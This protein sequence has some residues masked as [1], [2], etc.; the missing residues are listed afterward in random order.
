MSFSVKKELEIKLDHIH[1]THKS[2]INSS[3]YKYNLFQLYI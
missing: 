1:L 3:N 2:L